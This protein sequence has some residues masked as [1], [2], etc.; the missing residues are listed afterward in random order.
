MK[1]ISITALICIFILMF[2]LFA[3]SC[4]NNN[5]TDSTSDSLPS[6][7]ESNRTSDSG[8]TAALKFI[9][10]G[11][12][13]EAGETFAIEYEKVGNGEI[14]W[15]SLDENVASVES[16]IVTAIGEGD[17]KIEGELGEISESFTVKV[18]KQTSIPSLKLSAKDVE[19]VTGE[20]AEVS[21]QAE[22]KGKET[23]AESYGF[24]TESGVDVAEISLNGS[25]LSVKALKEGVLTTVVYAKVSGTVAA[26]RLTVTVRES[27]PLIVV[28]NA[29]PAADGFEADVAAIENPTIPLSFKPAAEVWENGKIQSGAIVEWTME[30][31]D[32]VGSDEN[33][34]FGKS[35]GSAVVVGTYKGESV[36]LTVNCARPTFKS[37]ETITVELADGFPAE[38]LAGTVLSVKAGDSEI[39]K[40]VDES[41]SIEFKL[42]ALKTAE[43]N[44]EKKIS[45]ATD[46]AIYE[47]NGKVVTDIITDE[48][49]LN[50]FLTNSLASA[51][52]SMSANGYFILGN[53]IVCGG[54]YKSYERYPFGVQS[55]NGFQGVFDGNGKI[56]KNLN[57]TGNYCGFIPMMGISGILKDVIFLNGKLSGNGGFISCHSFGTVENVYIEAEI[58]N[59][60][61]TVSMGDRRLC[62]SVI[63]SESTPNLNVKNVFVKYLS[64]VDE[65]LHAGHLFILGDCKPDGLIV[66][67]HKTF[68]TKTYG[69]FS[70][71]KARS[72]ATEAEFIAAKDDWTELAANYSS[73]IFNVSDAGISPARRI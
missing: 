2:A 55:A 40:S 64:E 5:Q 67:G 26:E 69:G 1:K 59:N 56:I 43:Y 52:A 31:N 29:K 25:V 37:D 73:L 47:Y 23:K 51:T 9:T 72:Y 30:N 7:S 54:E 61:E 63:A 50:E 28:S 44:V 12:I 71:A 8:E 53:D 16:G 60:S 3:A 46:K 10:K 45:I 20:T 48:T 17:T 13:L 18:E 70:D 6:T 32:F 65:E 24:N 34:Y 57:V 27:K 62:A 15:K 42:N 38:S 21:M 58:T 33:G 35:F 14:K 41:G 39:F 36:R 66:V 22:Y 11:A 49:E 4:G 68:F 19:L